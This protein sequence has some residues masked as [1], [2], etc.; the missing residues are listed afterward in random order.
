LLPVHESRRAEKISA[1]ALI[2]CVFVL[3]ASELVPLGGPPVHPGLL[4]S[5]SGSSLFQ[6]IVWL[7]PLLVGGAMAPK[8]DLEWA[9]W[10]WWLVLFAGT[11]ILT[12]DAVN[13]YSKLGFLYVAYT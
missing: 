4:D 1:L 5:R 8:S 12:Y 7:V 3:L 10:S 11:V 2:A 9:R 6:S 13:P